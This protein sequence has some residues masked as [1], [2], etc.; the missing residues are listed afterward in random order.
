MCV[1]FYDASNSITASVT[2]DPQEGMYG[3][4]ITTGQ[5]H[6]T[7]VLEPGIVIFECKNGPYVQIR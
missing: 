4:D 2:L 7:E 1:D 5:L 6:M 3:I